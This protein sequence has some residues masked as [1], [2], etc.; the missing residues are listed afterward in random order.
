VAQPLCRRPWWRTRSWPTRFR[1]A[2]GEFTDFPSASRRSV[3]RFSLAT[4]GS[5]NP[6]G[7]T[8]HEGIARTGVPANRSSFVGWPSVAGPA[9]RPPLFPKPKPSAPISASRPQNL[10]SASAS[11][12]PKLQPCL[13]FE[14]TQA[15]SLALASREP[16][17]SALGLSAQQRK[18]GFSP[19]GC[20]LSP[21]SIPP[22]PVKP[23]SHK[24][25]ANPAHSRGVLVM[26]Q[27][28]YWI[29]RLEKGHAASVAFSIPELEFPC[30][31]F[32]K[33]ILSV[34]LLFGII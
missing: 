7:I 18:G 32:I 19:W 8:N 22:K 23:Q 9:G 3:R 29:Q 14:G 4:N 6:K 27:P 16:K 1:F 20:L 33:K 25:S 26:S 24:T 15:F 2:C 17:P 21:K 13:S 11:R 12:P 30:N 10:S 34:T 28:L 31:S 5:A